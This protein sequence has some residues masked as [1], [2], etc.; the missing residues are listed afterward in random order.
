MT[1]QVEQKN[2][3]KKEEIQSQPKEQARAWETLNNLE[4]NC[5]IALCLSNSV[6]DAEKKF[7]SLTGK[8]KHIFYN[9]VYPKVKEVWKDYSNNFTDIALMRLKAG[10]IDA[11]D[12]VLD[13][14]KHPDVEIRH[15]ASKLII[16]KTVAPQKDSGSTNNFNAPIQFNFDKYKK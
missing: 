13:E 11:V 10:A 3:E 7:R 16:E 12:E 4:K 8:G 2:E 14:I 5:V 15:K 1:M 9:V 6:R